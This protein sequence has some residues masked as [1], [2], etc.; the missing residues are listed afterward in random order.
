MLVAR[1]PGGRLLPFAL[2]LLH[3]I[4]QRAGIHRRRAL[5][6]RTGGLLAVAIG[7]ARRRVFA[8]FA[9]LRRRGAVL[10]RLRTIRGRAN[11]RLFGTRLPLRR[12]L[13]RRPA[14]VR[15]GLFAGRARIITLA[16]R[17]ARGRCVVS[18]AAGLGIPGRLLLARLGLLARALLLLALALLRFRRLGLA[19]GLLRRLLAG[20]LALARGLALGTLGL[21]FRP[22]ALLLGTLGRLGALLLGTFR[23]PLF[24]GAFGRL[25]ALGLPFLAVLRRG[26]LP[27][28]LLAL[29]LLALLLLFLLLLLLAFLGAALQKLCL[30]LGH[31]KL[32][33]Q[34]AD[35]GHDCSGRLEDA[36]HDGPFPLDA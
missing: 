6:A 19:L 9:T 2:A 4:A 24:L 20:R 3:D 21:L 22:G 26:L 7:R 25:G 30:A 35:D 28:L 18:C 29:L 10:R 15:T 1:G 11:A 12:G 17:G 36:T 33:R 27:M 16:L 14:G 32:R 34:D 31:G 23:G 5:F 13:V 8:T